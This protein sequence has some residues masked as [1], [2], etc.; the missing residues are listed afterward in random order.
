MEREQEEMQFLGVFGIYK[1]AYKIIFSWRKIFSQIT[2][3]L[4]L[5]L[6][7]ILLAH[8]F[9]NQVELLGTEAG[10]KRYNKLSHRIS[11][12]LAYFWLFEVA[13]LILSHIFSLLS[14]AAVVYTIASIYTD[15]EVSFKKVMSVVPKVWKR[16]MV[17]FLSIF[18]AFF[19]YNA[20]AI[21]VFSAVTVL[22]EA[23]GFKA[24]TKSRALIKGKM[25][26]TIIIFFKLKLSFAVIHKAFQNLVVHG[27][28]MNTATRVLYGVICL[29][30]FLGL[31]L[32]E[33]VIQTVIYFVCKSNHHEKIEK[34][35]LSDHLD[36]Y[37]GEYVPLNSKDVQLEQ[38]YV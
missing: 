34:L 31:F 16:L 21:L 3:A 15:R 5:P 9:N 13:Y 33:L 18:V 25:W 37:H 36:V 26:T 1:E 27:V 38:H 10:T 7:F 6:S 28:S 19:A 23:C 32:F 14:T 11:S 17:T 22:E 35:A 2:L 24:M 20:V 4:I 29:S 12:E 8:I 30:L